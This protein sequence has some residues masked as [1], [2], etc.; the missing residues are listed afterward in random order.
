[1]TMATD[2]S[3][4]R[5]S[6][7]IGGLDGLMGGGLVRRS[8]AVVEGGPGSGKSIFCMQF[9]VR[10]IEERSEPGIYLSF[11]ES[12]EHILEDMKKFAWGL[13]EKVKS[14]MLQ[15]VHYTPEQINQVL[16]SGGG[17]VRDLIDASRARRLVVDSLT[18]FSLLYKDTLQ[19]RKAA[20]ALFEA[21]RR[22]DCTALVTVESEPEREGRGG[23]PLEFEADAV[24]LLYNQRREH[25]RERSIEILKMRGTSHT[26]RILPIKITAAGI[27]VFPNE[28]VF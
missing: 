2:S 15:I 17:T 7:G 14:G 28:S 6:T 24:I 21:L 18:A 4:E 1:M 9:L 3:D 19:E 22:W 11:E 8:V 12:P 5:V 23:L 16:T 25:V 27:T 26:N 13:P 20:F 10:G